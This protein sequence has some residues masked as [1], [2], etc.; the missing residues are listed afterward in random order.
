MVVAG[1][2]LMLSPDAAVE[3]DPVDG[4]VAS[5]VEEADVLAGNILPLP[6]LLLLPPNTRMPGCFAATSL[7]LLL[8]LALSLLA[9]LSILS[10][11]DAPV[12]SVPA[13]LAVRP[14]YR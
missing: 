13:A 14:P 2:R 11:A 7:L 8:P 3:E 10:P 4:D 1:V 9:E 6:L 12:S 5:D